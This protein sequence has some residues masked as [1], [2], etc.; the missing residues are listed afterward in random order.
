[1]DTL[2]EQ[3]GCA[4]SVSSQTRRY[5]GNR[6]LLRPISYGDTNLIVQWRNET[7]VKSN[8]L[9]QQDINASG[10]KAYLQSKVVPR[11]CD[12]FIIDVLD[13]NESVGSVFLK[14]I[15][16]QKGEG[17]FGIFIGTKGRGRG[18]AREATLLL[19]EHAFSTLGLKRVYLTVFADNLPGIKAYEKAGFSI[20]PDKTCEVDCAEGRRTLLRMTIPRE[21]F[22]SA[23]IS[24]NI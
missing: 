18:F 23:E 12:Q 4:D 16:L 19:L 10:H 15:D 17:E 24:S 22:D 14:N 5:D 2:H 9:T 13:T 20:D 8:L 7:A 21:R 11:E 1:M 3:S 6:V